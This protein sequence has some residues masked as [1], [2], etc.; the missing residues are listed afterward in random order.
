MGLR[1]AFEKTWVQQLVNAAIIAASITVAALTVN[2]NALITGD[3]AFGGKLTLSGE[4]VDTSTGTVNDFSLLTTGVTVLR[5]NGASSATFTGIAGGSNGRVIFVS[6]E[7]TTQPLG[8]NNE[9]AGSA[10]ANRIVN[11]GAATLTITSGGGALLRYD[12]TGSRWHVVCA[13]TSQWN[14]PVT[15]TGA[16]TFSTTAVFSS[17]IINSSSSSPGSL[18]GTTNDWTPTSGCRQRIAASAAATIT[19]F[20]TSVTS[21]RWNW[22]QNISSFNVTLTHEGT[23]STAANRFANPGSVDVVM[24]PG[25]SAFLIYDTTL[26][27]WLVFPG[28]GCYSQASNTSLGERFGIWTSGRSYLVPQ[29]ATTTTLAT[30]GVGTLRCVPKRIP[31]QVT[32]TK[33]GLEITVAGEA[34]SK[35]RECLYGDDGTAHPG[36]LVVD[37]GQVD[38]TVVTANAE[39]TV[40]AVVGP[41][42]YWV[43]AAV[44]NVV[45]TQPTIRITATPTTYDIDMETNV[46]STSHGYGYSGVTAACPAT[47]SSP[48]L[49]G[50][51]PRMYLKT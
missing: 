7:S 20:A 51:G 16:V 21:G 30:S 33:I 26:S 35:V 34:G 17:S 31:N 42:I 14:T 18:S 37:G 50:G 6:N 13:W 49:M 8:L 10:A 27:R 5:W 44:Q 2:G 22:F 40:S 48:V 12:G 36:S 46:S 4:Q 43:C 23:G 28:V 9:A 32:I 45:T 38:G 3:V 15:F 11:N 25:A 1:N 39:V 29:A 47:V 19:G 24:T 41:G